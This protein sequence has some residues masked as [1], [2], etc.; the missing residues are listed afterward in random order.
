MSRRYYNYNRRK[1]YSGR[2]KSY[3]GYKSYRGSQRNYSKRSSYSSGGDFSA[4]F[5]GIAFLL[6]AVVSSFICLFE[7]LGKG[8]LFLYQYISQ[9]AN[10]KYTNFVKE[11][12]M[13]I[14][15]LREINAKY[16]FLPVA[17]H[18]M[19]NSYDN[20]VLYDSVSP[21]DYLTYQLVY[22]KK[23][24][25]LSIADAA[26]NHELYGEYQNE[27]S[28]IQHFAVYD[29][30]K[31]PKNAAKLLETEKRIFNEYLKKPTTN[32]KITV[33][34]VL[35]NIKGVPKGQKS[36]VFYADTIQALVKRLDDKDGD[37]YRDK[38]IWDSIC[39]VERGKVTNKIRFAVYQK[40]NYRC[41]KCG[42]TGELEVDHIFPIA[43]GGKS[44]FENLQTLC[45]R[46]NALKSDTVEEGAVNPK[47][48][49][50]LCPNCN[51]PLLL[52]KGK[53]GDFYGCPNYPRCKHTEKL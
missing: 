51:R 34:I 20:Q 18:D 26:Q 32:F 10:A 16:A 25:F 47:K 33:E 2:R 4:L 22:Q 5:E 31:A 48:A 37:F 53:Y 13:A 43:K 50:R 35:T 41:A 46:C 30:E 42:S 14:K 21:L 1:T 17:K 12:S 11:H 9:K 6:D 27:V 38:E 23:E 39:N 15:E 24:I 7:L 49:N 36:N 3:S 8:A 29:A 52:K 28:R 45:H 44:N 40:Y 19:S